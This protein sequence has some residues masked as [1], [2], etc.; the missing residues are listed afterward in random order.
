[1]CS[2]IIRAGFILAA[3]LV[4]AWSLTACG[5]DFGTN[6]RADHLSSL[7]EIRDKQK[8]L[9]VVYKSGILDAENGE[10]AII[11]L[12]LKGETQ[13]RGRYRW[14]YSTL[15]KKL[16]AYILKYKR[17]SPANELGDADFV[18]FFNLLEYRRILNAV[19]PY[20]ELFVI[21]KGS[22]ETHQPPRII[23]R[24]RKVEYAKDAISELIRELKLLR[25]ED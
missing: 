7:S 25:G 13:P 21:V 11:D 19:Y 9:L 2:L 20:G 1:V 14:V 12:V 22:V 5:Q 17:L 4:L 18:I 24:S 23:W 8:A 3:N 6:A 16:N 15:A 10:R